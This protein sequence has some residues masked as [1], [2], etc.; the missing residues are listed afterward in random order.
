MHPAQRQHLRAVFGRGDVT[1][2]L[3]PAAHVGL[4]GTQVAVGVDL[5]LQ[6]A[7]AED[8][9]GDHRHHVHPIGLR[10]DDEGRG[11]VVGIGGG[12]ADAGDE[13]LVGPQQVAVP[14][15]G[16]RHLPRGVV[17]VLHHPA[18]ELHQ[19]RAPF[20]HGL[21]QQHDRID[22]DQHAAL[23][24]VAVARAGAA[25]G[26]LAQDGAGVALHLGGRHALVARAGALEHLGFGQLGQAVGTGVFGHRAAESVGR[27]HGVALPI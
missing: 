26:D 20:I 8:A 22:A 2:H 27:A 18:A 11:L 14:V 13:H 19:G 3:A 25:L 16:L 6:A 24:G 5:H 4:F 17:R 12:R 23:V 7:I 15:G 9:L 10:A 1:H 21:A